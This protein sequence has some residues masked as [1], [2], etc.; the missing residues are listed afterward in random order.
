MSRT[1]TALSW[2]A[3]LSVASFPGV[4]AA[5]DGTGL[6]LWMAGGVG[7]GAV[8][9]GPA[10]DAKIGGVTW[11]LGGHARVDRV[12]L[13]VRVSGIDGG[14]SRFRTFF[15]HD[16]VHDTFQDTGLLVGYVVRQGGSWNTF[17]STGV[18][19]I[20]GERVVGSR[21]V[22]NVWPFPCHTVADRV[23][24][25][26]TFGALLEIGIYSHAQR[27]LGIGVIGQLNV[28]SEEVF[29]AVTANLLVGKLR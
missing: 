5:W 23:D 24:L 6:D 17:V 20:Q 2:V 9:G 25:D 10:T 29:G 16:P 15:G 26:S 3:I 12:L 11:R 14:D 22:C 8:G 21:E 4:S 1:R 19:R 18:G 27:Y 13:T 28:N 7:R